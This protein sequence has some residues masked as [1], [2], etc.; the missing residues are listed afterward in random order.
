MADEKNHIRCRTILEVLGKPKEHVE[1]ALKGYIEHIK[2][3]S[4]LVILNEELSEAK[5]QGEMFS[6]FVELDL[7]VKSTQ[8]LIAFCFQYMPSSLEI[9]KPEHFFMNHLEF[10]SFLNDLQGRLH[11]VDMEVKKQKGES[12]FLKQS[13]N[14]IICNSII[15]SLRLSRMNLGQLSRITGVSEK[16]IGA[17]AD[18]LV[19]ENKI[20]KE[21]DIYRLPDGR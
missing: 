20:K 18:K 11:I 17:F 19:K 21:G 2:E 10:S 7:V 1:K 14:T 3:D 9:I 15:I 4:D 6:Q 12:S 8:K 13:L 16:E 5:E